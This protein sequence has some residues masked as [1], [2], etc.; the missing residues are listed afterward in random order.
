MSYKPVVLR[1]RADRDIDEAIDFYLGAGAPRAAL[2]FIDA[3]E[4]ALGDIERH[5]A[6]GSTRYAAELELPGLR[7]RQI[8]GFPQ[9]V[10]YVE[11]EDHVDVWRVLHGSRDIPAWLQ[12]TD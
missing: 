7:C 9:I 2:K 1:A 11:R 4:Q 10:F 6:I 5:P 8:K 3:L 12:A